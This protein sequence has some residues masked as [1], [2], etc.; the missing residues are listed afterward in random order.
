MRIAAGALK[1]MVV[2]APPRLRA[3]EGKVRQALF[4][5][6]GERV[7][8]ARVVDGFAGSGALGLE[9][10][11]RGASLVLFL[12]A[13]PACV[14]TM[15]ATLARLAPEPGIGRWEIV[16]G[17]AL[18]GLR[19]VAARHGPFDLIIL[20]PPYEGSWGKK[21]LNVVADCAMLAPAGMLCME[22]A[23]RNEPPAESGSLKLRKRHRYGGTVLSFYSP[24]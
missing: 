11:S 23:L 9:A 24:R 2:K 7:M 5:I 12:E 16:P 21:S 8:G 22:H 17:D 20:D 6:L 14:Q 4:N 3:T 13:D 19:A 1:G 10:L 15:Q 18:R